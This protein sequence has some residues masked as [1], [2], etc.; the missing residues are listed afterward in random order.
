M[1]T[2][3]LTITICL[4]VGL[5]NAQQKMAREDMFPK[6]AKYYIKGGAAIPYAK[7]DSVIQSWGGKFMIGRATEG[8]EEKIYLE[9]PDSLMMK[10][11]QEKMERTSEMIGKVAPSFELFDIYGTKYTLQN[12]KGKVIVL[13]FWFAGCEPCKE[14]MPEL[15][16]L[17][18]KYKDKGVVF[19]AI[20]RDN[21]DRIKDFLKTNNFNY[22]LLCDGKKTIDAYQVFGFP[23]S[24]VIDKSG[25][26]SYSQLGGAG[27]AESLSREIDKQL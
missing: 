10:H 23:T 18:E 7:I 27:I 13:N 6:S 22:T 14:E 17:K 2:Y 26:V 11:H 9:K 20:G 15:N 12:L 21:A 5:A 25:L 19:L 1:K 16:R 8:S 4:S 3:L 24:M